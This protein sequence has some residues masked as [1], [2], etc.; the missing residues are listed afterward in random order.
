MT[1]N[2]L[3]KNPFKPG[4]GHMPPHLA[5]R[6]E[7]QSNFNKILEQDIILENLILTGL[8]GTGKT[9]LLDTFKPIAISKNWLWV[10]SDLSESA[11]ISE[12]AMA[13]RLLTDLSV[14]TSNILIGKKSSF[15]FD[16]NN[17]IPITLNY[18]TLIEVFKNE[19]GLISDRLKAT[20]E[21]VWQFL[22]EGP[23]IRGIIF[24]YDEA[25]NISD[26]VSE[27]QYPLSMLLDIFQSIQKKNIPFMLVMVGLPTIFPKFVETRT[28]TERMFTSMFLGNLNPQESKDAIIKPIQEERCPVSFEKKS[29]DIIIKQSGGYPYFI[30]FICRETYDSF[31]SQLS[32]GMKSP[33]VPIS[34][35]VA[36]LDENFFSGRWNNITDRQRDLLY[37]VANLESCDG[38]FTIQET[39]QKSEEMFGKGKRISNSQINQMF[40]RLAESGLIYKT[41]F[42]KYTFGIPLLA[43]YIK[44]QISNTLSLL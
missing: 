18:L 44:R 21:K 29:I 1:K 3:F 36:K 19:N 2:A 12:E 5:G 43:N 7:E 16:K 37:V 27:K 24:A 22:K 26:Q 8:R 33:N 32:S 42:G 39:S 34:E 14:V 30:Q 41:R 23:K 4:S 25:Q 40:N 11:S 35:I 28:Y 10:G 13:T 38:E 6:K 15:G 20:L 9:V 17:Q 31:L